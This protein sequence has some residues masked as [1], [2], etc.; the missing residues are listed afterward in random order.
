MGPSMT[1][2]LSVSSFSPSPTE[3][4]PYERGNSHGFPKGQSNPRGFHF[5]ISYPPEASV[6]RFAPAGYFPQAFDP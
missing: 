2:C 5:Q 4:D 3:A 1:V 6:Q